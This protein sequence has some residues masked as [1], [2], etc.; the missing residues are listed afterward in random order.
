MT[1]RF[2]THTHELPRQLKHI[3]IKYEEIQAT[4]TR[5]G[6]VNE[7]F[8]HTDSFTAEGCRLGRQG[9]VPS[10]SATADSNENEA[11]YFTA[12]VRLRTTVTM[13]N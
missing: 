12:G 6:K 2:N 9:S 4:I 10:D 5:E 13:Q 8:N 7:L 11:I 3:I 1:S